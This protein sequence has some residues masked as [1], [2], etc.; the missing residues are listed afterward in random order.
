MPLLS[1]VEP[2]RRVEQRAGG[3]RGRNRLHDVSLSMHDLA[4]GALHVDDRRLAGDGDRFLRG[5]R[6]VI[7]IGNGE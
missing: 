6:L 7:S 4:A 3:A 2:G 1:T 5:R